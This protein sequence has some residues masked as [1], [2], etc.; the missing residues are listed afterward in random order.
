MTVT[1]VTKVPKARR[2][3]IGSIVL[4]ATASAIAFLHI[5]GTEARQ[6]PAAVLPQI[7]RKE[8]ATGCCHPEQAEARQVRA[9]RDRPSDGNDAMK[10]L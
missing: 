9:W 4:C 2:K 8:L 6:G 10:W 7:Y 3:A 5:S 1:P